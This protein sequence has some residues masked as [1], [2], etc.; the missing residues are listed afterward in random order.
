MHEAFILKLEYTFKQALRSKSDFTQLLAAHSSN[1]CQVMYYFPSLF[2]EEL[3]G[4][5]RANPKNKKMVLWE[6]GLSQRNTDNSVRS[7]RNGSFTKLSSAASSQYQIFFLLQLP[8]GISL[9]EI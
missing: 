6:L 3:I 5:T 7:E 4:T 9:L 8:S 2:E 1:F